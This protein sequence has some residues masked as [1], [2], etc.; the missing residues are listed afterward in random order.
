MNGNLA[1][2]GK[3]SRSIIAYSGYYGQCLPSPLEPAIMRFQCTCCINKSRVYNYCVNTQTQL[4]NS[5]CSNQPLGKVA[6]LRLVHAFENIEK[7]WVHNYVAQSSS[8]PTFQ[9]WTITH[10]Q[11]PCNTAHC[12]QSGT[13]IITTM[14]WKPEL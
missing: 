3:D 5:I 13:I 6:V 10:R 2:I 14:Q 1:N 7:L 9:H 12:A 4:S 11:E 8:W